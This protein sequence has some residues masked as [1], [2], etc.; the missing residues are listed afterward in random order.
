MGEEETA[1]EVGVVHGLKHC[2]AGLELHAG[3]VVIA[4]LQRFSKVHHSFHTAAKFRFPSAGD[5][6]EEG[7]FTGGVSADYPHPFIALEIVSKV[8]EVAFSVPVET[9]VAA[10]YDLVSKVRAPGLGLGHVHLFCHVTVFGPFLYVPERLLAVFCLAGAGARAG[11]HP[12][13][14]TP[15]KVA[16]FLCLRVVIVYPL[17]ALFQEIHVVSAIYVNVPAVHFHYGIAHPVKEIA[18]MGYHEKSASGVLQ[19]ALKELDGIYVKVVGGLVHYV[20]IGLRCQHLG[21]GHTLHFASG[22]VAHGFVRILQA[23]LVQELRHAK[24]I[25]PHVVL[26]QV[27]CPLRR[28]IHYLPKHGL[29]GI[30]GIILLQ[31]SYA[32]ILEKQHLAAAVGG[33]LPCQYL[34]Q[35]CLPRTIWSNQGHLVPLIDIEIDVFKQ[36][37]GAVTL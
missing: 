27:L 4:N 18:V 31:E 32:Y 13:K 25:L 16:N 11:V 24:F 5:K 28:R 17:L 8:F 21:K 10:I 34:Q 9:E 7:G 2:L 22:E 14:F 6:I 3:L 29:A 1:Q 20:E 37:L 26:V 19:V 36:H 12:L 23:E 35:G 33:V 30:K 15:E